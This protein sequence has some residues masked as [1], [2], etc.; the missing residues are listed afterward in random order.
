MVEKVVK[1][2]MIIVFKINGHQNMQHTQ[3]LQTVREFI[4]RYVGNV[5]IEENEAIFASGLV[6]S[7]FAMQLVLFLEKKF[8]IQLANEDLDLQNFQSLNTI[9][10]FVINKQQNLQNAQ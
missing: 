3:I 7:L 2:F 10:N 4:Q 6:N 5:A 9:A 1:A 8:S